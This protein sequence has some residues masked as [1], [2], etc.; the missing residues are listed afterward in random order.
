[1]EASTRRPI[2]CMTG[3][4]ARKDPRT[5]PSFR[6]KLSQ[7]Q[8]GDGARCGEHVA[9]LLWKEGYNHLAYHVFSSASSLNPRTLSAV[10]RVRQSSAGATLSLRRCAGL[11]TLLRTATKQPSTARL[12]ECVL[13]DSEKCKREVQTG[14]ETPKRSSTCPTVLPPI[15]SQSP[16]HLS[17]PSRAS[18]HLPLPQT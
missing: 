18:L 14:T 8:P 3:T 4:T 7:R 2:T 11:C 17:A 5:E 9:I 6:R 16:W 15:P 10:L 1:M 13:R 12:E